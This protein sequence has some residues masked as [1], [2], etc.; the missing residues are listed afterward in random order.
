MKWLYPYDGTVF[1]RGLAA[2]VLQWS[3]AAGVAPEAT[4]VR[5]HTANFE[6]RGCFGPL[7]A[8]LALPQQ[9]WDQAVLAANGIATPLVVELTTSANGVVSGPIV[10]S[11]TIAPAR[12]TGTVFYNTYGSALVGNNGAVMRVVLGQT[13]QPYL[14][15]SGGLAPFGPCVSCHAVS[16]NGQRM[17]AARHQYPD[18]SYSS[19]S[20]PVGAAANPAPII[21]LDEAGL[22]GVFPDGSRVMTTGSPSAS[23]STLFPIGPGNVAGMRGPRLSRLFDMTTGQNLNPASWTVQ[24]AKMPMFAPDGTKI[25]FNHHEAA[26]GHSLA[27]MDYSRST[28]TFSNLT[29]IY[30][31]ATLWPGW[32]FF[33]PDKKGVTFALGSADDYVS[34]HPLRPVVANSDLY[35]VDLATKQAVILSRAGGF[36]GSQSYLPYPGRDEHFDF[37]PALSPVAAG[38]YFW[39]FFT[40]R[41]NYGNTI[42]SAVDVSVSKN[43]WVAA[44]DI[45]APAGS[46]PSHPAFYLPGQEE[47]G[48]YRPVFAPAP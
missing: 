3:P 13:A 19:A 1:P 4:Y 17:V 10:Q 35:Y 34:A 38:G 48:N 42:V 14:T 12:L 21:T 2:P 41:R 7:P 40:S 16:A 11:W 29:P 44:I 24:Y 37:F 47:S 39:L 27:T 18:I 32:P 31:H 22:G 45:D 8:R 15:V 43:I 28:N 46:D 9:V 36:D 26:D 30:Q 6:Y 5:L 25:V 20:Y 33:T 23:T